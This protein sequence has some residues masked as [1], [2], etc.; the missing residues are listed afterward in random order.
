MAFL[1]YSPALSSR[2]LFL[3]P[4]F[5][6]I[7]SFSGNVSN[8]IYMPSMPLLSQV[9]HTTDRL[10]QLSLTAWFL[11]DTLPQL[12]FGPIADRFGRRNL[13][14]FGGLTFLLA[15]LGCALSNHIA[16]MLFFRF[17]QGVGVCS[18]MIISFI[19][20][21]ELFT[22]KLC[23]RWLAL[24]S[25]CNSVAPLLG[26]LVGGYIFLYHGW[27]ANFILVFILAFIGLAGLWYK[28]P[29]S[30][31]EKNKDALKLNFLCKNYGALLKNAYF[32]RHLLAYG[33][34]FGGIIAYLS[35]APFVIIQTLK[36]P[37]QYFGLTQLAIFAGY[38]ATSSIIGKIARQEYTQTI[39]LLSACSIVLASILMV[40]CAIYFPLSLSCFLGTMILYCAGFGFASSLLVQET[41]QAGEDKPGFSAALLGFSMSGFSCLGSFLVSLFYNG[42]ILSLAAIILSL[43]CLAL[44]I[45][46]KGLTFKKPKRVLP[47]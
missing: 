39:I 27:R 28:M 23:V 8:D 26:P 25:I 24:L 18:L 22:D 10:V 21:H 11:G 14:F 16:L 33:L 44:C 40:F 43:S 42:G 32:L 41:L 47:C 29:E 9:F 36:I 17:L 30:Q 1:K 4:I 46:F 37:A 3:F 31:P 2:N 20:I 34:F 35:G 38:M 12:L 45:F 19:V 6:L 13:L 15:T 7:Y 5:L